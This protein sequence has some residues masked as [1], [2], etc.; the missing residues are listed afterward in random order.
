MQDLRVGRHKLDIR[1]WREEEQTAFEVIK[2]DPKRVELC[3][4]SPKLGHLG[5]LRSDSDPCRASDEAVET[6]R[7]SL[8]VPKTSYRAA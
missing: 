2:G 7:R 4:I 6:I 5:S 1:F 3:D 8:F